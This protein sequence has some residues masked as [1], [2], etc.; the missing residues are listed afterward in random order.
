MTKFAIPL[1]VAA[2][3]MAT[4]AAAHDT[5]T[6]YPTRGACESASAAM[7]NDERDWLVD[8][9]PQFFDTAGGA[10]SFLARAWTCDRNAADGQVYI[11]DHRLEILNSEWFQRRNH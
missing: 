4:A 5:S 7:S 8:T 6:G 3:V 11:T 10:S 9:F 1:F 2:A